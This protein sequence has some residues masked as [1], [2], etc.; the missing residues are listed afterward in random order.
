MKNKT[1]L[2][3]VNLG[4]PDSPSTSDVR[5]YLTQFLNDSRVIDINPVG[6][7]F[8]VNAVIVPFRASKSAKIYKELWTKEGS[9]LLLHG[10]AL[11]EKLQKKLADTHE[12]FFGMRYQNPSLE[13]VL[14]EIRKKNFKKIIVF[15]LYPH[16]A[17][18]STGSSLEHIMKIISKWYVI[19]ELKIIS[20]YYDDAGYINSFVEQGKKHN[21]SEY[22]HVLF[23]YHGLPVRQ[24]D[25]VYDNSLCSDHNCENEINDEN[26]YCYKA[27]CY[28]TTRLLVEKL[29]IPKDKYTVGFQSRLNQKWIE[30]FS[31]KIVEEL[32]KKGMKKILV[33]SPAFTADCL[34]T[35]I[36]IGH[37]YNDIFRENGGEKVQLIESLNSNDTWVD[38]I[39][40]MVN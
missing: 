25:K 12:V 13:S 10:L 30:P 38:A 31:D 34:E 18:S 35:T 11:K 22:D 20:Q 5:R 15:P 39:V 16:Y 9:P 1:A 26:K 28:E 2:L 27:T 3:I 21:I 37:E 4:T 36:E 33:F 6:R 19:P 29:N 17:S 40:E 7:F 24:V 23:S 32:A 14:E 8:L